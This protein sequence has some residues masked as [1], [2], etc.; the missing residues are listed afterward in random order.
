MKELNKDGKIVVIGYDSGK[1]QMDAI[2]SGVD[3][4]RDHPG[5]GRHRLQGRRGRRRRRSRARSCEKNIDTGFHWYDK[6]NMD[7]AEMKPLL[8]D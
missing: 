5:P 8:Y 6:T 7:S 3:G 4:R 1:Q 2:R